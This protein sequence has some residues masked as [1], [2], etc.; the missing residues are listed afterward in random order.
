MNLVSIVIPVY[1]GEQHIEQCV[2][3]VLKQTYKNIEV[4]LI[5]DGST[6]KSDL[7]CDSYARKCNKI[8]VFHILNSG[9]AGARNVGIQKCT[10]EL[11]Y[12]LDVD[13]NIE[14]KTIELLVE[15][16]E[17][18]NVE[19]VIGDFYKVINS[20]KRTSGNENIFA[21]EDALLNEKEILQ[22]L[23]KYFKVSYKH[24]LFNH[25]WNRLYKTEIIKTKNIWF[26]PNLR[27]L[28]DLDFNFKY[29]DHVK[30][31]FYKN[32]PLYNYTINTAEPTSQSFKIG[33][34]IEDVVEYP[35]AFNAIK[36]FLR[37]RSLSEF[38]IEKEVGHF[39]ISFTIIILIRLC[40]KLNLR[41][42]YK[43][44]RNV[45]TIIRATEV[46]RNL[47]F[48]F[49]TADD[50]KSVHTLMKYKLAVLVMVVC[51]RR[52]KKVRSF[53]PSS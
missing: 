7:I 25:I 37:N 2:D 38:D 33:D 32:A 31:V 36:T 10:G 27:N 8:K 6:D 15:Q 26:N 9:P 11:I 18:H 16:Y 5:N 14:P 52:Y 1:N 19:L 20:V 45:A 28:E 44:Y 12:F 43:I 47:T 29:L 17:K 49:P 22:Y 51:Y 30:R 39:F 3:S 41:N 42:F 40:G 50:I 48:Y 23:R 34:D 21:G 46:R 24:L 13:D 4:M 53:K 35:S